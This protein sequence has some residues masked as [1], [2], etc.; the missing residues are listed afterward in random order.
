MSRAAVAVALAVALSAGAA[1]G[2]WRT[3]LAPCLL[4]PAWLLLPLLL[5]R[6]PLDCRAARIV[7]ALALGWALVCAGLLVVR[8]D[9]PLDPLARTTPPSHPPF[10]EHPVTRRAGW[11]W[12]GV[13]GQSDNSLAADRVPF[14]MGVDALLANLAF[15]SALAGLWLA[16]RPPARV[17]A[18]VAPAAIAAAAAGLFGGWQLVTMFD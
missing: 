10:G 2:A 9:A 6:R 17:A 7:V 8:L 15:W 1:L 11:P 18:L 5:R 3:A 4:A 16:R 12:P 13:E 14:A